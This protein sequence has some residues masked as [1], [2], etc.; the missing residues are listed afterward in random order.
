MGATDGAAAGEHDPVA[1]PVDEVTRLVLAP[2]A[3]PM[4]LEGTNT[5]LLGDP[6]H[7]A[8]V[9]VDPGPDDPVHRTAVE[10]A[11]G[12]A[13][14]AAV[15]ITHHHHDHAE[16]AGWAADWKAE[17]RAFD[18]GMVPGAVPLRDGE[19]LRVA[20]LDVQALHTPGHAS[21]H[22][23]LRVAETDVVLTGDHI[24]GRGT[25]VVFWPDGDMK[26]YLTSLERLRQAPGRRIYPGHGPVVEDPAGK[27]AEYLAHRREREEQVRR[28]IT[29]GAADAAAIVAAVYADVPLH[30]HPAALRSTQAVLAK[31]VAEGTVPP[32]FAPRRTGSEPDEPS[33]LAEG[34]DG[35]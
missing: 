2:N 25:T 26:Q 3:S 28:A 21:D 6:A 19:H 12:G 15:I 34:A 10:A 24:L 9:V 18:P 5:Y 27:V 14:V 4:T 22:L 8:V 16:A 7:G 1:Q 33:T 17:L 32:S 29:A 23:C 13:D 35:R 30:L 31:M 11:L 20:G